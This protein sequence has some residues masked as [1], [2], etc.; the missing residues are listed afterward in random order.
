MISLN[1]KE[2]TLQLSTKLF[3]V[4]VQ[5][6]TLPGIHQHDEVVDINNVGADI[7]D[8]ATLEKNYQSS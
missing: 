1:L 7:L 5:K 6:S 4:I 8:K 2:G 3:G